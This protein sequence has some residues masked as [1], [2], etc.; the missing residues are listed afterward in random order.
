MMDT[1][2][3]K[4]TVLFPDLMADMD[5]PSITTLPEYD[6]ALQNF[7]KMSD[8]GAFI[9]LNVSGIEKS[10][11][12]SL[13][14][15]QIPRRYRQTRQDSSSPVFHL[16]PATIRNH[17][18]RLKYD[19]RSFFNRTNSVKTLYGHFLFRQY[20]HLWDQHRKNS[21]ANILDYLKQEIGDQR[22]QKYF[23]GAWNEAVGWL[24]TGIKRKYHHLLPSSNI[25]LIRI[26][27]ERL[28]RVNMTISHLDREDQDY[29]LNCLILKTVHVPTELSDYINGISVSSTFKT[30]HLEHLKYTNIDSLEDLLEFLNT[31]PQQF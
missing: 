9:D 12:F 11:S 21:M 26:E 5:L 2:N 17:I 19:A 31:L 10:F 6:K 25:E 24:R 20:F 14:E 3:I 1:I 22:Y 18:N 27:R 4:Q 23:T 29:F 30:I 16:F 15:L 7:I 13:N 8:Y 28:S